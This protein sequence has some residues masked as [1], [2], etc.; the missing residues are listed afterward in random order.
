[1]CSPLATTQA[2][3]LDTRT[4]RR[5]SRGRYALRRKGSLI[6]ANGWSF[7]RRPSKSRLDKSHRNFNAKVRW[8]LDRQKCVTSPCNYSGESTL[9]ENAETAKPWVDTP[10]VG[11]VHWVSQMVGI[12]FNISTLLR[13]KNGL[14][15]AQANLDLINCLEILT[16]RYAEN[17]IKNVLPPLANYS[18]KST[19][20]ENAETAKPC[21][22]TP[23]VGKVFDSSVSPWLRG[24]L[25]KL[26]RN[27]QRIG[28]HFCSKF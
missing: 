5:P 28:K 3:L 26:G 7:F 27:A 20:H 10:F 9:H 2:K 6:I 19:R 12:H 22:D 1:M 17:W 16:Q 13:K 8:E 14:F 4:Q 11:K 23:V 18:G 24:F 21:V 15:V 25:I